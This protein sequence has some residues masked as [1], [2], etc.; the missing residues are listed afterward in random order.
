MVGM[1]RRLHRVRGDADIAVGP[2]LEADRARKSGGKLTMNLAFRRT[3]ADCCPANQIGYVLGR[4]DV[5]ELRPRWQTKVVNGGQHVARE[6]QAPVD[7]EA[8]IEVPIVDHAL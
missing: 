8:A 4:R 1:R 3:R 2:I 7:I 6:T 5:E